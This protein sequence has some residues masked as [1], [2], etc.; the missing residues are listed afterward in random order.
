MKVVCLVALALFLST[1]GL[2]FSQD[3]GQ[4]PGATTGI[5]LW[6]D[7]YLFFSYM[8]I[9]WEDSIVEARVKCKVGGGGDDVIDATVLDG[10]DAKGLL[11][12]SAQGEEAEYFLGGTFFESAIFAVHAELLHG[13]RFRFDGELTTD[14]IIGPW[15][16]PGFLE[17]VTATP[18]DAVIRQGK[19]ALRLVASYGTSIHVRTKVVVEMK[20]K[21]TGEFEG[22]GEVTLAEKSTVFVAIDGRN[23]HV[24][25]VGPEGNRKQAIEYRLK[26]LETL[27][28]PDR[29]ANPFGT[30]PMGHE[31]TNTTVLKTGQIVFPS[32]ID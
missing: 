18:Y 8:F 22:V 12:A 4:D 28:I 14:S 23:E 31:V 1:P 32:W 16:P 24:L 11:G 26:L 9:D 27:F 15:L 3:T 29:E 7:E 5:R 2:L 30:E 20:N 10:I 6:D 19:P 17:G 25:M 13:W 21:D